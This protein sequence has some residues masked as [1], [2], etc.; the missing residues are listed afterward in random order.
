MRLSNDDI[1]LI[2]QPETGGSV[3]AFRWQGKPVFRDAPQDNQDVLR[4]SNY[5]LVPYSNRIASARFGDFRT[6]PNCPQIEPLHLIHGTGFL[7]KW[8]VIGEAHLQHVYDGPDWPGPFTS[9]QYFELC[10]DGYCHHI[11]ITND[12]DQ[13]IPAGLGIHPHFPR[14]QAHLEISLSGKWL[15]GQSRIPQ[16][17]EPLDQMPEWLGGELIDEVFTGRK[18]EI[19]IDWPTHRLTIMPDDDLS[20]TVI[21]CP[22][23]RDFFCV[24]PVT[25]MID[26]ANRS[27]EDA[28]RLLAPGEKWSVKTRFSVVARGQQG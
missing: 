14:A 6:V 24:E 4:S 20:H 26:A 1:E 5:P 15:N 19:R 10:D 18:G 16:K 3:S 2:I 27:G 13:P 25:H 23:D 9:H 21:Y 28:M 7:A 11:A 12:G 22:P 17:W 8:D